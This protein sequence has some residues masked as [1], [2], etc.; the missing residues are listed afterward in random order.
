M[1]GGDPTP[2]AGEATKHGLSL[3]LKPPLRAKMA[4]PRFKYIYIYEARRTDKP[5]RRSIARRA[6]AL[7]RWHSSA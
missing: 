7:L 5:P 2:F 6:R 4:T 3:N 1:K